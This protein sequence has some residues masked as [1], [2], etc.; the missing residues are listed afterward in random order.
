MFSGIESFYQ[1][2]P[3][4]NGQNCG[5]KESDKTCISQRFESPN[6]AHINHTANNGD[7][8]NGN[9]NKF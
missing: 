8:N 1:K 3:N 2:K 9:G 4:H 5:K 6:I 7:E